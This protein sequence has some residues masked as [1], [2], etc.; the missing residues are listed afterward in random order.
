MNE[1]MINPRAK[2]ARNSQFKKLGEFIGNKGEEP[3]EEEQND[4]HPFKNGI[5]HK[6]WEFSELFFNKAVK[7]FSWH[8]D[9]LTE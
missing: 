3:I 9:T 7:R 4:H 5:Y 2:Q 1:N 8:L 6:M